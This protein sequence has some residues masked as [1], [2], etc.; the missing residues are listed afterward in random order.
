M[1]LS[2]TGLEMWLKPHEV[3]LMRIVWAAEGAMDSRTAWKLLEERGHIR[4]RATVINFLK[5]AAQRGWLEMVQEG[6]K[7]GDRF[8]YVPSKD[9][10]CEASFTQELVMS[11]VKTMGDLLGVTFIVR[12]RRVSEVLSNE[13][14]N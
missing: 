11:V 9:Y 5:G 3:E 14:N 1:D 7:G 10:P 2:Q 6:V 13:E 12:Q 8:L 4:S